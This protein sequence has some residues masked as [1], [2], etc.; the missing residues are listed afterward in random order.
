MS[1]K[2]DNMPSLLTATPGTFPLSNSQK[3]F[4]T[5]GRSHKPICKDFLTTLF[6]PVTW[7]ALFHPTKYYE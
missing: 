5:Q 6:S 1:Q 4:S 3:A 2:A 7:F